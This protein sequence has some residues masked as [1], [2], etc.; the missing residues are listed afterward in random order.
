[1]MVER[2]VG[3]VALVLVVG[4]LLLASERASVAI[5]STP[6]DIRSLH[7]IR[8]RESDFPI[9]VKCGAADAECQQAREIG[10]DPDLD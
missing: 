3:V 5:R 4:A 7:F 2:L 10:G 6:S 1:M 8:G 9:P